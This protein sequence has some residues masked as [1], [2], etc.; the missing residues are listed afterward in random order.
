MPVRTPVF[1]A[2]IKKVF[3]LAPNTKTLWGTQRNTE[4]GSKTA[5]FIYF[6]KV[7]SYLRTMRADLAFWLRGQTDLAGLQ[8][9]NK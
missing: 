2:I 7:C 8:N 6:L 1:S 5:K 9:H 3:L 4:Y